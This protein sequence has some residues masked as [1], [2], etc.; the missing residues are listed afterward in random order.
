MPEQ[1]FGN[2]EGVH[3]EDFFRVLERSK[4]YKFIQKLIRKSLED[5]WNSVLFSGIINTIYNKYKNYFVKPRGKTISINKSFTKAD[6]DDVRSTEDLKE[7]EKDKLQ[8]DKF[9]VGETA[10]KMAP[11]LL[12]LSTQV[13]NKSKSIGSYYGFRK[14]MRDYLKTTANKAGQNLIDQIPT[15]KP[16]KFRLSNK[17][18]REKI[19]E[20]VDTLVKGLDD[21]TRR[22]LV[23]ELAKGIKL[24]ETKAQMIKRLQKKG[25]DFAKLRAKRIVTTETEAI[26]E[27][28]RWETARLNGVTNKTWETAQDERVCPVCSPLNG[29]TVPI[30]KPFE[31]VGVLYPPAHVMCRCS[32]FYNV[33]E[34]LASNFIKSRN[35]N[36]LEYLLKKKKQKMLYTPNSK[37]IVGIVNPNAVWA[38]GE[39]LVGKDKNITKIYEEIKDTKDAKRKKLLEEAKT[40]LTIE[41]M[42][43][44]RNKLGLSP[45]VKRKDF[46]N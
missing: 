15:P 28:M 33:D 39:S 4:Q 12:F 27:F 24:K 13:N 46:N 21:V 1:H 38:G 3:N 35:F 2:I 14:E 11:F 8:G 17:A 29:T 20:R 16:I 18:L 23:K 30:N 36:V 44:L 45:N 19:A 41:G 31:G 6:E 37:K 9:M 5:Q 26:A 25:T 40:K 43:Q 42:V 32:V 7:L 22:T 10:I 34:V